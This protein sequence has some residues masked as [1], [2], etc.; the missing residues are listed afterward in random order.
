MS[1]KR[2][3]VSL[4]E[5]MHGKPPPMFTRPGDPALASSTPPPAVVPPDEP[6]PVQAPPLIPW[7]DAP[8]EVPTYAPPLRFSEGR[9]LISLNT[10][11]CVVAAAALCIV[12]LASYSA[13]RRTALENPRTA[14]PVPLAAATNPLLPPHSDKPSPSRKT[15]EEMMNNVDLSQLLAPPPVKQAAPPPAV[16]PQT[17]PAAANRPSTLAQ[18]PV[19]CLR[20]ESFLLGRGVRRSDV[21]GELEDVRRFLASRGVESQAREVSN[22]F[23]LYSLKTV[24]SPRTADAVE[25][26]RQV[27]RFGKEYRR[28]GGRYE[29]KGCD[30]VSESAVRGRSVEAKEE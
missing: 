11:G 6:Q 30:F 26:R 22:G 4:F 24:A 17:K 12:A 1:N 7:N 23:V 15:R 14:P 9:L 10:I 25:F 28:S 18:K 16:P 19:Q 29:F 5:V 3:K 27:E 20:I 21:R 13:G 8:A 2:N